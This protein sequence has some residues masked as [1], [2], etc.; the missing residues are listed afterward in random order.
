MIKALRLLG[1]ALLMVESKRLLFMY[2][3]DNRCSKSDL[4]FCL[5]E[6][7]ALLL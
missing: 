3:D 5:C 2:D 6:M 7:L 4:C 1:V